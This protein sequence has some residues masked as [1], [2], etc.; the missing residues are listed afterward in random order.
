MTYT[1]CAENIIENSVDKMRFELGD[2]LVEGGADTC[3]L[4]DEEYTAMLAQ[5]K[6]WQKAKISCLKAI[7]MKL[8]YEVDYK[9]D[10]MSLSLSKRYENLKKMLKELEQ[11][12][13]GALIGA[14]T[15]NET[16]KAPYFYL[17]MQQNPKAK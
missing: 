15:Y 6:T 5:S 17:G 10:N 16:E 13:T 4:C 9:V 11:Q 2:T 1:Y 8:S 3:L 14:M 12:Q 7:I